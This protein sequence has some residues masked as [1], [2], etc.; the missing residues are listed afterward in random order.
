MIRCLLFGHKPHPLVEYARYG[1][2]RLTFCERCGQGFTHAVVEA[3]WPLP[4]DS[5]T[6][7]EQARETGRIASDRVLDDID[8]V[9]KSYAKEHSA[10]VNR[11]RSRK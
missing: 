5:T 10:S 3:D 9:L 7:L 6:P 4:P 11:R 2:H 1:S 8:Y